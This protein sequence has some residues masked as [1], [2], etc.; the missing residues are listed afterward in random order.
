MYVDI[1]ILYYLRKTRNNIL[2]THKQNRREWNE[3]VH[4]R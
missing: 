4:M 1:F 3:Q 2:S